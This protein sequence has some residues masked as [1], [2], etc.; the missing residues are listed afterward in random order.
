MPPCI[1]VVEDD[2]GALLVLKHMVRK[3]GFEC[4][5]AS[6]GSQ[7]INAASKRNY[8]CILIDLLLPDLMGTD[9]AK[10]ILRSSGSIS[11]PRMIGMATMVDEWT[12]NACR[13]FGMEDVMWKPVSREDLKRYLP[14][15]GSEITQNIDM[16]VAQ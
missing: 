4:D 14:A 3:L 10:A 9:V 7:A 8:E 12:K 16:H 15:I 2:L 1:L 6:S 13:E 11:H 5:V